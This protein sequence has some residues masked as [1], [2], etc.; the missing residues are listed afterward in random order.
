MSVFIIAYLTVCTIVLFHVNDCIHARSAFSA[1][2][3]HLVFLSFAAITP[4]FSLQCC[5][6]CVLIYFVLGICKWLFALYVQ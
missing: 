1:T 3:K 4:H 6:D 5:C 2:T